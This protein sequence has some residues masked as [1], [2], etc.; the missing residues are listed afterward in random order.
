MA[1]FAKVENNVVIKKVLNEQNEVVEEVR[2]DNIVTDVIV[3][4]Q[5]FIDSGAMGDPSLW[6]QTS[7]NTVGGR[8]LLGGT[9]LR[10]NFAAIGY[11]YDRAKDA[12]IPPKPFESW[13]LDLDT[14]IWG[15]P[16]PYPND[17]KSYAWDEQL[18]NWKELTH[19]V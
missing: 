10:K 14:C 15:P 19:K 5:E 12:F 7:Y 4:D 2:A 17:G 18:K 3:A 11:T 16:I 9:P 13:S 1:S 6:V 8:H